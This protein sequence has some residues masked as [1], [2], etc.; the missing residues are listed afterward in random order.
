[1]EAF[2]K[3]DLQNIDGIRNELDSIIL[4]ILRARGPLRE[5]QIVQEIFHAYGFSPPS[6]R[7]RKVLEDHQQNGMV[8]KRNDSPLL[9]VYSITKRGGEVVQGWKS[10]RNDVVW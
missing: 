9:S 2:R 10:R 7:V 6:E 1:M 8:E 3:L 4:S 5:F